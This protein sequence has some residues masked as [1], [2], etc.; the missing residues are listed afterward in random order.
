[1]TKLTYS[2]C[3]QRV[4]INLLLHVYFTNLYLA[5]EVNIAT[6]T[7]VVPDAP[8]ITPRSKDAKRMRR[9]R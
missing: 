8:R 6:L 7:Q 2:P 4:E 1:M 9:G 5:K 3:S